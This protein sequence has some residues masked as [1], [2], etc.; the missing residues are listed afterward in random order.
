MLG[1]TPPRH[2]PTLPAPAVHNAQIVLR[3]SS[4]TIQKADRPVLPPGRAPDRLRDRCRRH[5][6]G[7]GQ[8]ARR[9][10][11]ETALRLVSAGDHYRPR[12][13]HDPNR[14]DFEGSTDRAVLGGGAIRVSTAPIAATPPLDIGLPPAIEY[15][16]PLVIS[17][18]RRAGGSCEFRS[19]TS[20]RF[21]M[22]R[23]PNA[24]ASP[25][26]SAMRS[27]RL[28]SQFRSVS[29]ACRSLR[30][31]FRPFSVFLRPQSPAGLSPQNSVSRTKRWRGRSRGL[32]FAKM[33]AEEE[34]QRIAVA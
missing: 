4:I 32:A 28:A 20:N 11:R 34:L 2:T 22:G 6:P 14:Q 7:R 30:T 26:T 21:S 5:E 29:E 31:E 3:R 13:S 18:M 17:R 33:S 27:R 19:S 9:S 15:A 23:R 12:V 24:S 8:G 10:S 25:E 1:L 16:S